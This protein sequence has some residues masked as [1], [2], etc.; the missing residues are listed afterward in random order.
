MLSFDL[1][2]S[3]VVENTLLSVFALRVDVFDVLEFNGA[4]LFLFGFFIV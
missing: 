2:E 4:H 3:A 1:C